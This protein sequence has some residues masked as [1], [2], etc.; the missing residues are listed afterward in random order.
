MIEAQA[1]DPAHETWRPVPGLS[2]YHVSDLGRVRGPRGVRKLQTGRDGHQ[3][4]GV[5]DGE[6]SRKVPVHR[7]VLSAFCGPCPPGLECCHAD[8]NP[9]NNRLSNLRWDTRSANV[10]DKFRNGFKMPAAS[11]HPLAIY[12]VRAIRAAKAE[13]ASCAALANRFGGSPGNIWMIVT[14][15][16]WR[17]VT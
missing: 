10:L 15:K 13:G 8:D 5:W 14:G 2:G 11:R 17:S 4:V 3:V 1:V 9:A 12:Q 6:K 7:L 16:T